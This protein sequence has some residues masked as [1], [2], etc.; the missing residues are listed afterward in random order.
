MLESLT[1]EAIRT[2]G[3]MGI[4][5][6]GKTIASNILITTKDVLP[7]KLWYGDVDRHQIEISHPK[8][9]FSEMM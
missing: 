5:H 4:R 8:W 9:L 3:P 2:F 6:T 1:L 7:F